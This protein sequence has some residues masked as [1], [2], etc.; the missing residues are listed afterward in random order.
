[1]LSFFLK[2]HWTFLPSVFPSFSFFVKPFTPGFCFLCLILYSGISIFMLC[3]HFAYISTC[4]TYFWKEKEI[5]KRKALCVCYGGGVLNLNNGESSSFNAS[6]KGVYRMRNWKDTGNLNLAFI[7]WRL[8]LWSEHSYHLNKDFHVVKSC[9]V[10]PE[11]Q[12]FFTPRP[13]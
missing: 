6:W 7:L 3:I 13:M 12:R 2:E 10:A 9:V 8:L 1:M 4:T 11:G 5:H